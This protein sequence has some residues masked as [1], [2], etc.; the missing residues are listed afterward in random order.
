ML[1]TKSPEL[2]SAETEVM[3]LSQQ[4]GTLLKDLSAVEAALQRGVLRTADR[5]SLLARQVP[6]KKTIRK[7][8]IRQVELQRVIEQERPSYAASFRAERLP[9]RRQKAEA[10]I[11]ACN[12]LGA[13]AM[14][15]E[16]AAAEI[17]KAGG[18]V[19]RIPGAM[20][21]DLARIVTKVAG[22]IVAESQ[23][24]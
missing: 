5:E 21:Q 22:D 8:Q 24:G 13:A 15:L 16:A 23:R 10:M 12:A 6:I 11:S 17:E 18:R 2:A 14:E 19:I 1:A 9:A 3:N 4:H 20:I 7:I